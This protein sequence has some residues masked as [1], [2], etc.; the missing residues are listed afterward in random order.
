MCNKLIGDPSTC[1][2]LAGL[3]AQER[4]DRIKNDPL[5]RT[6]LAAAGQSS[7]ACDRQQVADRRKG[8]KRKAAPAL[9]LV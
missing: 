4:R 9:F 3:S 8:V 6:C 7:I 1:P 2:L 5:I